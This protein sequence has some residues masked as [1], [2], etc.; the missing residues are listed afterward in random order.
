[1]FSEDRL[2]TSLSLFFTLL[3]LILS[4]IFV[5]LSALQATVLRVILVSSL[6]CSL[7]GLCLPGLQIQRAAI[8][9]EYQAGS[10]TGHHELTKLI[11]KKWNEL[12]AE[13]K[14]VSGSDGLRLNIFNP[15]RQNLDL[16]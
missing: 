2:W 1:M 10:V 12:P 16:V 14:K 5:V 7:S 13:E 4:I 15:L 3:F 11:A 6:F 8:Q 9:E